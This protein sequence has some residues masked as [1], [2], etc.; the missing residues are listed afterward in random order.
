MRCM[1]CA[2]AALGLVC[3]VASGPPAWA[4]MWSPPVDEPVIVVPFGASRPAGVHCG[5]DLQAEPG[6]QVRSPVSGQ[7]VFAGAVPADGGGTCVAVTIETPDGF[8]I[9]LL[10]L[11]GSY[12]RSGMVVAGGD[13]LGRLATAGDDSSDMPHL[14]VGLRQGDRY[15]DP[16]PLLPAMTASPVQAPPSADEAPGAAGSSEVGSPLPGAAAEAPVSSQRPS[17]EDEHADQTGRATSTGVAVTP[18]VTA[19]QGG[20]VGAGAVSEIVSAGSPR[21]DTRVR[22]ARLLR[23]AGVSSTGAEH[24]FAPKTGDVAGGG[25]WVSGRSILGPTAGA[26][27]EAV[28]RSLALAATLVAAV[29]GAVRVKALVRV[30]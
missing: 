9:S 14:H 16:T 28:T 15:I 22:Q 1:S 13:S 18:V 20:L 27:G 2:L 30:R 12:V 10:P 25:T 7:V 3:M 24:G 29:A 11:D 5:V 19:S 17:V 6:A 8:R 23:Q 4:A 26:V 21:V